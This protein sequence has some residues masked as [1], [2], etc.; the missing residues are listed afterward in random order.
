MSFTNRRSPFSPEVKH[1]D[2][3]NITLLRQYT[4][5]FYKIKP[6]YYTGVGLR[7]QKM[8]AQALKRARFMALLPYN[9]S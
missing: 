8:L 4:T 9:R 5:Y 7:H 1:I 2:Y 6:R 3:K